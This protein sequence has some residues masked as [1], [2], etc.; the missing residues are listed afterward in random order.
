MFIAMRIRLKVRKRI[1]AYGK[2]YDE[3]ELKYVKFATTSMFGG[4][5]SKI[6]NNQA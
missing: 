1:F 6:I 5:P 2:D 3:R 4:Y